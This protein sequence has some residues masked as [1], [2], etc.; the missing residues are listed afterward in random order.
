MRIEKKFIVRWSIIWTVAMAWA[1]FVPQEAYGRAAVHDGLWR[2]LGW[3]VALGCLGALLRVLVGWLEARQAAEECRKSA[4]ASAK[5]ARA[6][7]TTAYLRQGRAPETRQRFSD[8]SNS[9][10]ANPDDDGLSEAQYT[11][12]VALW[13]EFYASLK[14]RSEFMASLPREE[15]KSPKAVDYMA[16]PK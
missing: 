9:I 8:L 6:R 2:A 12:I 4:Q 5:M 15:A 13:N 10:S 16:R 1:F 14:P 11:I 3:L 7:A